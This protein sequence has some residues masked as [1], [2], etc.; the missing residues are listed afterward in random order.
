MSR[1]LESFCRF[2][3]TMTGTCAQTGGATPS[4]LPQQLLLGRVRQVLLGADDV[5]D[6]H[7]DVVDHVGEEEQRRTV[8]ARDDE[9]LDGLVGELDSAAHQVVDHG[10]ALVGGAEAQRP[11]RRRAPVAAEPVVALVLRAR[12]GLHLV[13]GAVQ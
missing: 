5:G 10:D 1:R 11:L 9:V 6:A 4:A 3:L 2:S 7:L 13:A 8:G 12:A